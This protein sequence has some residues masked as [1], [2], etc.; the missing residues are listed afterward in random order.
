MAQLICRLYLHV[1]SS[2]RNGRHHRPD[3]DREESV[4]ATPKNEEK[5]MKIEVRFH[6]I[7]SSEAFRDHAVRRVHFHLSRFAGE[8]TA[9]VVRVADVNGPRGG[10]DKRCQVTLRGPR[11]G[12]ANLDERSADAYA[13][14]DLALERVGRSA[15]RELDRARWSRRVGHSLGR[16]S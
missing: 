13:A 4:T 11:L 5:V 3:L 6:G 2:F 14:L 12:S 10:L 1:T 15:G 8:V 9:V 7:E 16:A